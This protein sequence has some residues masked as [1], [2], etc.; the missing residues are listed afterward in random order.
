MS[1]YAKFM[2]QLLI[3]KRKYIEADTIEL[4]VRCSAIIQKPL[5]FK[6]KYPGSFTIPCTIGNL[7]I[8]KAL[9]TWEQA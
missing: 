8:D 9:L 1:T 5:P 6:H 7:S 4:E 2:K 3:K